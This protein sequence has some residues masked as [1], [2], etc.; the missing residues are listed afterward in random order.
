MESE[1]VLTDL[2]H[3]NGN[4]L[5]IWGVCIYYSVL[6]IGGNEMQPAQE[7]ELIWVV[8]MNISGLIFITWISGEIAVLIGQLSSKQSGIQQEIDI[9]NTAMK[10]AKLSFELQTEIRDYFLKVQGTM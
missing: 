9:M 3:Q 1:N 10:N 6:V 7:L 5:Y 4:W 2:D 8:V